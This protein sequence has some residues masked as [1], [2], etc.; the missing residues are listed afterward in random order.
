MAREV[1]GVNNP[2]WLL[3]RAWLMTQ[4]PSW[5]RE[6]YLAHGEEFAAW[7]HDKPVSKAGVRM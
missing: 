1:Y 2:R 5:L 3:F 4:A 7:I 6:T